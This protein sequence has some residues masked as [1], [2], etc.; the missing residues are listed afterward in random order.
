MMNKTKRICTK[1][2]DTDI[3]KIFN[4]RKEGKLQREIAEKFNVSRE[5]IRDILNKKRW[6]K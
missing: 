1:L 3:P 5:H 2:C 4:L 6:V